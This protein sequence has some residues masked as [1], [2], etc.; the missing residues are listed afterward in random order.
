MNKIPM[1]LIIGLKQTEEWL[2]L[3]SILEKNDENSKNVSK[4][5]DRTSKIRNKNL[6]A[7]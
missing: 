3:N 6:R 5:K 7:Y 2:N 4:L 1:K